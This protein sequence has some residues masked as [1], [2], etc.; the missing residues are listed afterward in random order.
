ME[1][2][3]EDGA[4]E[5]HKPRDQI[6]YTCNNPSEPSRLGSARGIAKEANY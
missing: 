3:D 1:N 6:G 2:R 4:G 5:E